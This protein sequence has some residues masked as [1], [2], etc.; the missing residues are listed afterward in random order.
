MYVS[1][2]LLFF[3][4]NHLYTLLLSITLLQHP[5]GVPYVTDSD[6][7]NSSSQES[8]S[9][10]QSSSTTK[11]SWRHEDGS[12]QMLNYILKDNS[13]DMS[14]YN[15]H[16]NDKLFI[17]EIITGV[18]LHERRGRSQEKFW[19]YDIVNNIRSGLDVDKLD[20][21]SRDMNMANVVFAS[22]FAR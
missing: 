1:L 18:P 4:S 22:S 5:N 16:N 2:N 9:A 8:S 6:N 3:Y 19:L 21:L 20:Y 14:D 12:V 10:S 11:S 15:L 7:A 17:E 13:I